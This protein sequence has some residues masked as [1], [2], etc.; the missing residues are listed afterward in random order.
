MKSENLNDLNNIKLSLQQLESE[1]G[2]LRAQIK[3]QNMFY[4]S[5]N[6]VLMDFRK[7]INVI[8]DAVRDIQDQS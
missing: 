2:D 7:D 6:E 5:F 8:I 4:V 1:C 3:I